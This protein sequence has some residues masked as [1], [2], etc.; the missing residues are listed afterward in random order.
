MP[1]DLDKLA[2]VEV[3]ASKSTYDYFPMSVWRFYLG[4]DEVSSLTCSR[5]SKG[6]HP[7]R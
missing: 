4:L 1:V 3:S 6:L 2:K 5:C 7:E